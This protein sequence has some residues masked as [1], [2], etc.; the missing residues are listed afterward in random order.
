MTLR[1]TLSASQL[2]FVARKQNEAIAG[3]FNPLANHGRSK[4]TAVQG[5]NWLWEL[6]WL[7]WW[8][9]KK[10][11]SWGQIRRLLTVGTGTH[12]VGEFFRG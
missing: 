11:H 1:T 3:L 8:S 10:T 9:G 12:T 5:A 6:A 4:S 2:D 7:M